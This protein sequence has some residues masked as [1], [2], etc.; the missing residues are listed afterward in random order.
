MYIN[1]VITVCTFWQALVFVIFFNQM[2]TMYFLLFKSFLI[3]IVTF[4]MIVIYVTIQRYAA[5]KLNKINHSQ[6]IHK[7]F[8][9]LST[10]YINWQTCRSLRSIGRLG[11]EKI[12]KNRF[13][14]LH[15]ID[16]NIYK[17]AQWAITNSKH[18]IRLFIS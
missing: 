1:V 10:R 17:N 18:E 12:V 8:I 7:P 5:I 16:A 2:F 4:L 3:I 14:V 15:D 9:M 6:T 13:T 11:P